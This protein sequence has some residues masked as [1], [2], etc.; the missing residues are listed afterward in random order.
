M[1]IEILGPGCKKCV[2][3]GDNAKAAAEA[4]GR[5]ARIV[6]VTDFAKIAAYGVMSTPGLV[7]DGKVLSAGKVLSVEEIGRLL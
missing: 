4:A 3:L 6:K 7:V 5:A 1:I 2:T